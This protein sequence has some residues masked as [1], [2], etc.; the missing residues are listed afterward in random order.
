MES[1]SDRTE[2]VSTVVIT[3]TSKFWRLANRVS[4]VR[5]AL[6][7][8]GGD[9]APEVNIAGASMALKQLPDDLFIEFV[10]KKDLISKL[11]ASHDLPSSRVSIVEAPGS[12]GMSE[13]PSTILR[14]KDTSLY[15]AAERV[16]E[17]EA[18]AL[19]SAGNTGAVLAVALFV[20]GRLRGVER[21]AIAVPVTSKNGFTV[22]LDC[23]ANAEV[24]PEH[25]RDFAK[26]GYEYAKILGRSN[27]SIGLLSV[28]EEKEKGTA[29]TKEASALI[30]EALGSAFVGNVEGRDV[31][32]GDVDVIVSG[33]F[34]GNI[35][36][37]SIEGVA[38]LVGDLLRKSI[39]E[40]GVF[41]LLG[42]LLLK[43]AFSRLKK[44]LNP[45][46]YG[47]AFVLGVKGVV[48]KAHGSSD[49]LAIMNAIRVAYE[50][51]KGGLIDNLEGRFSKA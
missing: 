20:V 41:G 9:K 43:G 21:G 48:T 40:A 30:A 24:R 32:Y 51:V 36:L 31:V 28:G 17:K 46:E 50:G 13:K 15:R 42:G 35:A 34:E 37:K 8:H 6:D 5:I 33:G 49:E 11:T 44:T 25:L 1:P 39:K 38:K 27:P 22:L 7:V 16:K 19:V 2:S 26:M 47:G 18:D 29:L 10:G 3:E 14:K 12:F 23:G 45:S 4:S